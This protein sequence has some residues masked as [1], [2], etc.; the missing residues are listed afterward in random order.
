LVDHINIA[1]ILELNR[2]KTSDLVYI[3]ISLML[4]AVAIFRESFE[5][6]FLKPELEIDF[7][8]C[9]PYSHKTVMDFSINSILPGEPMRTLKNIPVYYFSFIVINRGKKQA[10][11]C[12]VVL[13][14]VN[15]KD[16][17]G[18]WVEENYIPVNL[19]WVM[20]D[21]PQF[22]SINPERRLYCNIGHILHPEHQEKEASDWR[23]M[24]AEDKGKSVFKLE[25]RQHFYYQRDCLTPGEY[26]IKVA[27]YSENAGKQERTFKIKWTGEWK[28]KEDDIFNNE[29][30]IR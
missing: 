12:E 22:V 17:D 11:N 30:I 15:K 27:I 14:E 23:F 18:N 24:P 3:I 7:R 10:R 13:E 8:N 20:P 4:A 25:L 1:E 29:I 9:P 2:L 28:E 6:A 16:K 19:K 5:R 21:N 26:K